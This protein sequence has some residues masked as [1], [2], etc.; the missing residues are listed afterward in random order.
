[1]P[2]DE[3]EAWVKM[4]KKARD[5]V[6]VHSLADRHE[7]ADKMKRLIEELERLGKARGWV[8]PE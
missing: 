3:R 1:M 6:M 7:E 5:L 2:D 8:A 4:L